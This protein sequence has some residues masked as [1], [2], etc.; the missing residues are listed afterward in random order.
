M[1]EITLE[2]SQAL[3]ALGS[4]YHH[5]VSYSSTVAGGSFPNFPVSNRQSRRGFP[6]A[7]NL[8]Q[9]GLVVGKL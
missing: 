9:G 2:V 3:R 6:P 4:V 1:F 8:A 7:I 5:T